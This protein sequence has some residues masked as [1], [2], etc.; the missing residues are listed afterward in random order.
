MV[1]V[2]ANVCKFDCSVLL[3]FRSN[4][5]D[6]IVRLRQIS[7]NDPTFE[8]DCGEQVSIVLLTAEG[9]S[10]LFFMIVDDFWL[11]LLLLSKRDLPQ[12]N[13]LI[14]RCSD[15][16]LLVTIISCPDLLAEHIGDV[17]LVSWELLHGR[18][19]VETEQVD[20][21]VHSS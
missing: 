3:Y 8:V 10:N 2:Q 7:N 18:S 6:D 19:L 13:C 12:L 17:V 4:L 14:G 1:S 9:R 5:H 16:N 21:V 15:Q 20:L 11:W